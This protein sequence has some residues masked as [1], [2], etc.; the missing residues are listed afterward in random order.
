MTHGTTPSTP[1]SGAPRHPI[2]L[3]WLAI[4][5][6]VPDCRIVWLT[7]SI[8]RQGSA[9]ATPAAS[10][11]AETPEIYTYSVDELSALA[12]YLSDLDEGS[13]AGRSTGSTGMLRRAA[14]TTLR[15]SC[16][17]RTRQSP[18]PRITI[19]ARDAGFPQL[20]DVNRAN[21][22]EFLAQFTRTLGDDAQPSHAEGPVGAG[23]G[24]RPVWRTR[25]NKQ[26]RD[27]QPQV[28]GRAGCARDIAQWASVHRV[29]G[30]LRRQT[31]RLP[32]R[33]LCAVVA[34]LQFLQPA[35]TGAGTAIGRRGARR[36]TA[37]RR[38]GQRISR[39]TRTDAAASA[40]EGL[41]LLTA[42]RVPAATAF[43]NPRQRRPARPA[44][45]A[46]RKFVIIM[47]G[48]DRSCGSCLSRSI[49]ASPSL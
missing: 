29:A 8:R 14:R 49:N 38:C 34:G 36:Q 18:L 9:A 31:G 13:A 11:P 5:S 20:R 40:Q 30:C 33:R 12:G 45:D 26:F 23:V 3:A 17:I 42:C 22:H 6:G 35:A 10:A 4:V 41:E 16:S 28:C 46:R 19:E 48:R 32:S 44:A 21:L 39:Q 15:D 27:R 47:T 43:Q 24:R 25:V 37:R 1:K 2:V 7:I